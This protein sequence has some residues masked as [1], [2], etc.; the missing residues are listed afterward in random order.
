M[1][2]V[3]DHIYIKKF[4]EKLKQVRLNQNLSQEA[5]AFTADIPI[6]QIGRIERGEINTTISTVKVLAEALNVSVKDNIC[7]NNVFDHLAM[8][9][10]A[11]NKENEIIENNNKDNFNSNIVNQMNKGNNFNL[12]IKNIVKQGNEP[13]DEKVDLSKGKKEKKKNWC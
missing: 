12:S 4:G 5:L 6:S 8:K 11:Q 10:L 3:K 13:N 1:N 9:V 2:N 7:V